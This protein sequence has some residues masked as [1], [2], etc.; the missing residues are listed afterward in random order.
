MADSLG[1]FAAGCLLIGGV[2]LF[3]AGWERWQSRRK[4]AESEFRDQ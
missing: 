4:E 2:L 1:I 3:T